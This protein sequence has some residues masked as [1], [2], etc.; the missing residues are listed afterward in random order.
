MSGILLSLND[1]ERNTARTITA[2]LSGRLCSR[3]SIEWALTSSAHEIVKR[4]AINELLS[5]REGIALKE[6]W[7]SAWRMIEEYWKA[8]S[9]TNN[10]IDIV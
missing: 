5:L 1:Q 10:S 6:P 3:E 2:F 9:K 4:A 7:L 8:P